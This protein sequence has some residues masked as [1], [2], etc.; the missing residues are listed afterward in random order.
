MAAIG[1]MKAGEP[2]GGGA[3]AEEGADG[4]DGIGAQRPHG[5]AVVLFVAGN[6]IVPGMLDDLPEG[7]DAGPACMVDGGHEGCSREHSSGQL[8]PCRGQSQRLTL[9]PELLT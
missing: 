5:A 8:S 3:A 2:G 7:R 1:A 4:G 6:E 9:T